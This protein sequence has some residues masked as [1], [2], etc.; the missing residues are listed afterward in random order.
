MSDVPV[1]VVVAA[2]QDEQAASNAL[3]E[4]KELKRSGSSASS[5]PP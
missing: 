3:E 2:F 1:Q 5:T 4:L